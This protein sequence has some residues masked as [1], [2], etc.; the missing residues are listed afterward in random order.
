MKV[1]KCGC[2]QKPSTGSEY[3]RWHRKNICKVC[4]NPFSA[5]TASEKLCEGCRLPICLCGCGQS[6]KSKNSK[7]LK[8]HQTKV[9]EKCGKEFKARTARRRFCEDCSFPLCKCGCGKRVEKYDYIKGHRP[10]TCDKCGQIFLGPSRRLCDVCKNEKK[11]ACGCG[12]QVKSTAAKHASV[13]KENSAMYVS[14]T[15]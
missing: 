4:G 15:K 8:G 5:I 6:V 9:C 13:P 12:R 14:A 11:C 10:K 7:Y 2:G 1:C 3:I